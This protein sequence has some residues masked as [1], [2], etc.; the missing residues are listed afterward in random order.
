LDLSDIPGL[1][2]SS[3][4]FLTPDE[5]LLCFSSQASIDINPP[6]SRSLEDFLEWR[7]DEFDR[8]NGCGVCR[9]EKGSFWWFGD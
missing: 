8:I 3:L 2:F 4:T 9:T 5:T 7:S 1:V 6:V